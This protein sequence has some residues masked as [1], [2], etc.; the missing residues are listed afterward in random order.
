MPGIGGASVSDDPVP[1]L[2]GGPAARFVHFLPVAPYD[3]ID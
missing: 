1:E 2:V 3:R